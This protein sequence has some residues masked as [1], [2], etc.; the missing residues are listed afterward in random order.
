MLKTLMNFLLVFTLTLLYYSNVSA[1]SG[2]SQSM[3]IQGLGAPP[4]T[5][6]SIVVGSD[7][8]NNDTAHLPTP[9]TANA[10][11]PI[12]SKCDETNGF[13]RIRRVPLCQFD[14]SAH[15][16]KQR[17]ISKIGYRLLVE[18]GLEN[19]ATEFAQ[20][21]AVVLGS[22]KGWGKAG[23]KFARVTNGED[24]TII[25]ARPTSVDRLCRPL[26]TKGEVSCALGGRA[27]INSE[28]WLHGAATWKE[29]VKPYRSYLISHEVGHLLGLSHAQCPGAGQP[30][31]IMLQQTIDL[32]ECVANDTV[33][34]TDL[35]L[36]DKYMPIIQKRLANDATH[37]LMSRPRLAVKK[38]QRVRTKTVHTQRRSA[39]P[40]FSVA[41]QFT[42]DN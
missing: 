31:P 19:H 40:G 36:L 13:L 32:Q 8:V 16:E 15:N 39:Q 12:I 25:L 35:K 17:E 42:V 24:M 18:K 5:S 3:S 10:H 29:N 23:L 1:Q 6:A 30:A 2:G 37:R 34:I 4:V 21:V 14:A 33:T 11:V 41:F 26:R 9:E 38:R 27:I 20:N 7:I 28:R 22:D